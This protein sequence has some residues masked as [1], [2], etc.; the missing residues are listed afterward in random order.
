MQGYYEGRLGGSGRACWLCADAVAHRV[1]P[2]AARCLQ[3][4]GFC[5][6]QVKFRLRKDCRD[7]LRVALCHCLEQCCLV[8][9]VAG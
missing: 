5:I 4:G 9:G 7:Q 8:R 3:R 6:W 1:V 2:S